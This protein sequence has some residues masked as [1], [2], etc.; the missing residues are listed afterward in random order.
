MFYN[1]SSLISLNL[2]HFDISSI[3]NINN[4]IFNNYNEN[5]IY[6]INEIFAYKL[7]SLLL[8]S[9]HKNCSY[10]CFMYFKKYIE[11]KHLCIDNYKKDDLYQ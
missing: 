7:S 1:C 10:F 9:F 11:S 3:T 2:Y 6:C 8:K 5:L 4:N